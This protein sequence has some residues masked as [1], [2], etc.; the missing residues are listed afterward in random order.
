MTQPDPMLR[1][2]LLEELTETIRRFRA[3]FARALPHLPP[4]ELLWRIQFMVGAMAH[5]IAG[6]QLIEEVH[7]DVLDTRDV[8]GIVERMICFLCAG[9]AAPTPKEG[10]T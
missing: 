10:P 6:T 1:E 4:R 2:S 7:G 8:D 9:L 3:A 5:T